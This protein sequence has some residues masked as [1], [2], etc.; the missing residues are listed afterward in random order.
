MNSIEQRQLLLFT[1]GVAGR[2]TE[3]NV[4]IN[5]YQRAEALSITTLGYKNL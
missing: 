1:T 3:H 5:D 2:N 4:Q